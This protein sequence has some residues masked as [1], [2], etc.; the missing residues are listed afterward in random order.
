MIKRLGTLTAAIALSTLAFAA[1][2]VF[3]GQSTSSLTVNGSVTQSCTTLSPASSTLTFNAY[4][5]FANAS[6]PVNASEVDFTTSCTKGAT[7]VNFSVNGGQNCTH[8][9]GLRSMHSTGASDYLNYQLYEESTHSTAWPFNTS[10]CVASAGPTLTI[11]S[12]SDTQTLT[13]FG[14]IPAGQDPT[15]GADYTD[16]VTVAINY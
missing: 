13:I 9:T 7:G 4:D 8:S 1:T 10:T 15:V 16:T 11:G 5:S 12:S 2:P 3:A 14:Q 6:T